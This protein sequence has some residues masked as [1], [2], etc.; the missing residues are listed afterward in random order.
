MRAIFNTEPSEYSADSE[1]YGESDG[2]G[3]EGVPRVQFRFRP[4]GAV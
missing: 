4:A 1:D 2:D 3:E